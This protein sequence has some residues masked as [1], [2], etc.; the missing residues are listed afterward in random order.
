MTTLLTPPTYVNELME[1]CCAAELEMLANFTPVLVASVPF[2]VFWASEFPYITHRLGEDTVPE[3]DDDTSFDRITVIGRFVCGH[4]GSGW[5]GERERDIYL[6]A[7]A[8]KAVYLQNTDLVSAAYPEA[9]E[10]LDPDPNSYVRGSGTKI[11]DNS[12]ISSSKGTMPRQVG[13]EFSITFGGALPLV[14]Y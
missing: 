4:L 1:R 6:Y 8:I 3:M 10:E 13:F 12:G 11:F 7:P 14:R 9:L 2:F 5:Q